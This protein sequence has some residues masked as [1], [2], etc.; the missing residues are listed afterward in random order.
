MAKANWKSRMVVL[1]SNQQLEYWD[2]DKLKGHISLDN[3]I[4]KDIEPFEA[5]DQH[6]AF[7]ISNA[8][9]AEKITFAL[10]NAKTVEVWKY[11][12]QTVI[13]NTWRREAKL[14]EL[15][16]LVNLSRNEYFTL[17]ESYNKS[18]L[19]AEL[20]SVGGRQRYEF[21]YYDAYLAALIKR[22][23]S[24]LRVMGFQDQFLKTFSSRSIRIRPFEPTP[25]RQ[26]GNYCS[27]AEGGVLL[28]EFQ[29][30]QVETNL[31]E[32]GWDLCDVLGVVKHCRHL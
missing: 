10:E 27:V 31:E 16:K 7:E 19:I 3:A 30:G 28:I 5:D 15:S 17:D 6:N 23:S 1:Y 2:G 22:I 24:F 13:D 14:E 11:K 12:I 32:L 8:A 29:T 4:V 26:R 18:V 25:E 20:S 9:H 21:V